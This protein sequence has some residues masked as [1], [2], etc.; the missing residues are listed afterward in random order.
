MKRGGEF[1]LAILLSLLIQKMTKLFE[2]KIRVKNYV[3][4]AERT[5]ESKKEE[6]NKPKNKKSKRK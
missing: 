4:P 2:S 1:G 5:E 6:T 3:Q